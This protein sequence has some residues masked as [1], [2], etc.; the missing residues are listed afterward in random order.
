MLKFCI[1]F[2][3]LF[4]FYIAPH[5]DIA[6]AIA[7]VVEFAKGKKSI[8]LSERERV[9]TIAERTKSIDR[10]RKERSKEIIAKIK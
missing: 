6:L 7:I 8:S 1:V 10:E 3:H 2:A 5:T 4:I 9:T